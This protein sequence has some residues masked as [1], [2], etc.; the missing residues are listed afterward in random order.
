M[1]FDEF[2]NFPCNVLCT[3]C[4]ELCVFSRLLFDCC[5]DVAASE[6]E[7]LFIEKLRQCMTLFDFIQDP[8][9]DLKWKEIKR[10]ALNELVEYV[11]QNRGVITDAI[12]PE[13]VQ[14]VCMLIFHM[15]C[16]FSYSWC[17]CNFVI[18]STFCSYVVCFGF[19]FAAFTEH[20][21]ST[22]TDFC[23]V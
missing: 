4:R 3:A 16:I 2:S 1:H 9:S 8:L 15:C 23:H 18:Y 6:R 11:T 17:V 10:A 14:M 13:A 20:V 12:Y 5:S 22:L 7:A 19:C 21:K